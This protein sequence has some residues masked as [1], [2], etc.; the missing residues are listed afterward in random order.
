MPNTDFQNGVI[1]GSVAGGINLSDAML[2]DI[3]ARL[4]QLATISSTKTW[5]EISTLT[6]GDLLNYTWGQLSGN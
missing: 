3:L 1:L 5:G 4:T 6:W 2:Q